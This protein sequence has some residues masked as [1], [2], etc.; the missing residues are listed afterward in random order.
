MLLWAGV[1]FSSASTLT[2]V[3][4]ND[5]GAGSLRQLIANANSGDTIVF[6]NGLAGTLT[7]TSGELLITNNLIINGPGANVLTISGNNTNRVFQ[8]GSN[9]YTLSGVTI[10]HGKTGGVGGGI[11]QLAPGG[12]TPGRFLVDSCIISNNTGSDGG[13]IYESYTSLILT[14]CLII[15]NTAT[16]TGGGVFHA[17]GTLVLAGS[18]VCSNTAMWGGGFSLG[19]SDYFVNSTIAGNQAS[20]LGGGLYKGSLLGM[21]NCTV[22]AN[23]AASG[24]GAGIYL[25]GG[26]N[27]TVGNSIIALNIAGGS[28]ADCFG[29]FTSLGFN[30][31]GVTNGSSGWK[32][33]DL[34]G[35]A[36]VSLDPV[37][38]PL[39]DNGGPTPTMAPTFFSPGIDQGNSF[40]VTTD[41]RGRVRPYDNPYVT[42]A[43]GG[44]GADIGA[45]ETGLRTLLVTNKNDQ[46]PGSLRQALATANSTADVSTITF[47]SNVVGAITLTSGELPIDAW[48]DLQGPGANVLTIDGNN[49]YVFDLGFGTVTIS[50]LTI[51]RG[52]PIAVN[53][54]ADLTLSNCAITLGGNAVQD[55]GT[56][57]RLLNCSLWQ[58]NDAGLE[59]LGANFA[60]VTNCTIAGNTGS[61]N[62]GGIYNEGTLT[63][64]CST[65][66]GNS[67]VGYG[68]GLYNLGTVDIGDTIIATNSAPNHAPTAQD[69]SGSFVSS[70]YNLIGEGDGSTGFVNGVNQDLVGTSASPLDPKFAFTLDNLAPT[71]TLVLAFGSPA[72]DQGYAFGQT[73]D[74]RGRLRP[75]D[76][77]A[78]PNAAGGDG[79][80][81]GAVEFG[82]PP[83]CVACSTQMVADPGRA[84][85]TVDARWFGVNAAIWD[86]VFDTPDTLSALSEMGCRVLRYPG[87]SLSDEYHWVT[88]LVENNTYLWPTR[89][90][91]FAHIATNLGAQVFITVN[92]GTGTPNEAADWVKSSNITNSFGFKY[93]EV[94]NE[95]YGLWETDSNTAPPCVAHDPWTYATRF[96]DYYTAM[97]AADPTI[98]VGIV[99]V[100]GEGNFVNNFNHVATNSR[101]GQTYYG[102]TPVLLATLKSLGVTP[103]FMVYHFYPESGVDDDA[104]LLQAA[105]NWTGDAANLRQQLNDYLGSATTNVELLCTENNSDS[106]PEG[107]QSTSLVNALYL[108]DSVAQ[109]MKTEFNSY[110]W[111]DLRNGADTSGDFAP[112]L[113]GWRTYGDFG[114]LNSTNR[115]PTF[116]AMKLLQYFAQAGD[117]VLNAVNADPLLST[118]AVRQAGGVVNVLAINK[119]P[120]HTI[121]HQVALAGFVPSGTIVVRSYGIPQDEAAR[122]NGTLEAQD[123]SLTNFTSSSTNFTWSFPP[124]SLTLLTEAS[125]GTPPAAPLL[126]HAS[127]SSDQFV[128]QLEGQPYI[129]YV[130]ASSTDLMTWTPVLTNF[131][132]TGIL[133]V[134]NPVAPGLLRQFWRAVWQ[135]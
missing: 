125:V 43:V 25:A 71:P 94:G 133:M 122:T 89:F 72:I 59:I 90:T 91:N 129:P 65:V 15:S 32:A 1:S 84:I 98:K 55:D 67:T 46:G 27:V 63:L 99:G 54:S 18:T 109:L 52:T 17:S 115:H 30:L 126:T 83:V 35:N 7:L 62:G 45:V 131:S 132:T 9:A 117:T 96:K 12:G 106:G 51:I 10:A 73:T 121:T 53:N 23:T 28:E 14:N 130:I 5:S 4:L 113:Y 31:I 50:D 80:D 103:D 127:V 128:F 20:L 44:D 21:T 19:G 120:T 107:R 64:R 61:A 134:T 81:I 41:Q 78:I 56:N 37:L 66:A 58:N 39:Q 82:A 123:I 114:I 79:S 92:Y 2:V 74:Q 97:K 38:T 26:E 95:C 108:A 13:G 22:A 49:S 24:P 29:Q 102:W 69:V 116:Y 111:W 85:R 76:D 40:G 88:D 60:Y 3:N 135:P 119:D 104:F 105:Y 70:G 118:Y 124:Y 77:P 6:S 101:T 34:V 47:A 36:I 87:G 48:L 110:V 86:S 33:S 16:S 11:Y 68:G 112:S 57:L 8:F 42:N 75:F 100:P 93:W